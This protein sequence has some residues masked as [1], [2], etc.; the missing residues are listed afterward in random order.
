[1]GTKNINLKAE[2]LADNMAGKIEV[3]HLY[4]VELMSI[5]NRLDARILKMDQLSMA[6]NALNAAKHEIE[7]VK[8]LLT[9]LTKGII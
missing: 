2:N 9:K 1:M 5:R 6:D 7:Q 4:A 3:I 8:I